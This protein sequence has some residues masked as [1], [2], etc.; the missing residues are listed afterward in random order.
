MPPIPKKKGGANDV[1]VME[2][3]LALLKQQ[4]EEE[5]L[6]REELLASRGGNSVW[7]SGRAGVI[8][9]EGVSE[10]IRARAHPAAGI[11]RAPPPLDR[12]SPSLSEASTEQ[13]VL[14]EGESTSP[15]P[16]SRAV[17]RDA[18][19]PPF[20]RPPSPKEV[21]AMECQ[22]AKI[23]CG[24]AKIGRGQAKRG[25]GQAKIGRGQAKIR[26]GQAKIGR[27]QAKIGRGQAQ[28]GRAGLA[29]PA[30]SS[31]FDKIMKALQAA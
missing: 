8:R 23:W 20:Q 16:V 14:D 27:G 22:T 10:L 19:P 5:R 17:S 13:S 30:G 2:Q 1:A 6:R 9:G 12:E 11:A 18:R 7:Q 26:R 21:A 28:G 15:L 4:M 25:R 29:R 31:Y 3:R 24:Q